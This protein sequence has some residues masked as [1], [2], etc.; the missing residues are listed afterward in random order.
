MYDIIKDIFESFSGN[1]VKE[2][3]YSCTELI[4]PPRVVMLS[5][6]YPDCKDEFSMI[7]STAS[8][9]GT[10]VHSY[11]ESLLKPNTDKYQLERRLMVNVLD[12]RLSGTFDIFVDE[13]HVFDIKTCKTWKL[14][15]EPDMKDWHEQQNIYAWML[16]QYGYTIESINILAIYLDWKV[17]NTLRDRNYPQEPMIIYPLELWDNS[18]AE[19]LVHDRISRLLACEILKDDELPKCTPEEMWSRFPEGV[20]KKYAVMKNKD[21]K[22]AVRVLLSKEDTKEYISTAKGLS[23][24]SFVEVRHA[25]RKRCDDYCDVKSKCNQ[26]NA[27]R[28]NI[29]NGTLNDII[30]LEQIWQ[31]RWV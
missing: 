8:V 4:S 1:Y 29:K 9:I 12:K 24:D 14:V 21:A 13:K 30:P 6:R 16:R 5:N 22:R 26:Y 11:V 25:A 23:S 7:K 18:K 27:Y 20:D 17:G 10:G 31:G 15:F 3:D 2:G 28:H 19:A